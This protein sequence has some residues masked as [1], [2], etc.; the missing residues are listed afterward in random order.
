[1]LVGATVW[2]T[3]VEA[4]YWVWSLDLQLNYYDHPVMLPLLLRV[5]TALLGDG[6][7]GI[8][9]VAVVLNGLTAWALAR[10][11]RV[12]GGDQRAALRTVVIFYA[13]PVFLFG[14]L[15]STPDAPVIFF[16]SLILMGA[17]QAIRRPRPWDPALLGLLVGL[18]FISKMS[19][20]LFG[21]SLLLI[22]LLN[23]E[24][25]RRLTTRWMLLGITAACLVISPYLL[26]NMQHDWATLR[27]HGARP[28]GLNLDGVWRLL[29][30]QLA[31]F[32]PLTVVP[33]WLVGWGVGR[34]RIDPEGLRH[35]SWPSLVFFAWIILRTPTSEPHWTTLGY[36][37]AIILLARV[38]PLWRQARPRLVGGV[39]CLVIALP[40][41]LLITLQ[42]HVYSD[43]IV[44]LVPARYYSARGDL[45]NDLVGWEQ[46]RD[47][48]TELAARHHGPSPLY[49]AAAHYTICSQL[50]LVTGDSPSMVCP[51]P[52]QDAFDYIPDRAWPPVGADVLFLSDDR[53]TRGPEAYMRFERC[54]LPIVREHR[55]ADRVVRTFKVHSC[56]G[57]R[58]PAR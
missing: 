54:D 13:M 46:V 42:V 35:L 28:Q 57:Y 20:G 9:C 36:L 24:L 50:A 11:T 26:W 22:A 21:L 48:V 32:G 23:S 39:T 10:T 14:G 58:G 45:I 49:T 44:R 34:K 40:V 43:A 12:L 8:R 41:V 53:F 15:A 51:S 33:L 1:M 3:D 2:L 31:F 29:I 16:C 5:S 19:A 47:V 30:G 52:R 56:V 6:A 27:Y 18:A 4:Y 7:L 38:L 37:P 55:R 17:A 25:R